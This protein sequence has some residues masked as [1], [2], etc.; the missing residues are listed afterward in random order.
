MVLGNIVEIYLCKERMMV[1]FGKLRE[2]QRKP[3]PI[4]P[5]EIFRRLPKPA[6]MN[7][8]Y[9]SQSDV[10]EKWFNIRNQKDIIFKLHTGGGKTL[11]GLL[12]AQSSLNEKKGPVLYLAPNKNLVS[13]TREKAKDI[14]IQTVSY[15]PG[16]ALHEDF[17]NG[18]AIMV[19]TYSALFNGRSKFGVLGDG[20]ELIETGTIILDDAHSSF[21][22]LRESF[23]FEVSSK[24]DRIIFEE[25]SSLFRSDFVALEKEGTFDSIMSG[26]SNSILE[27]PYWAWNQ[28]KEE[29][30]QILRNL[31][32]NSI[33]WPLI[34][35]YLSYCHAI[36]TKKGFTI[37]PVLPLIHL[38]P[39]FQNAQRR[40]YMS[41][42]IADDSE[43]VR[44]F[45]ISIDSLKNQLKSNSLAGI[46]ERMILI[47]ELMPFQFNIDDTIKKVVNWLS[48][49]KKKVLILTPSTLQSE[50]WRDVSK[51]P[52]NNSEVDTFI[53]ELINGTSDIPLTLINRYDGIDLPGEACRLVVMDEL[54]KGTS[55]Y[56][57]FRAMALAGGAAI[58][59]LLAQRIEQ[60]IG[61]GAR[62]SGDYCI[63]IMAGKSLSSWIARESNFSLLTNATRAQIDMGNT[64]SREISSLK[65]LAETMIK[66]LNRDEDWVEYHAETLAES[67]DE[68]S[69]DNA[70]LE[71]SLTE[72]K[73]IELWLNGHSE[74]AISK[75]REFTTNK[76]VDQKSKGW[77]LQLAAKIAHH[78]GQEELSADLQKEAFAYNIHLQRPQV[79]PPYI[80]MHIPDEQSQSISALFEGY[81]ARLGV[82][83]EFESST[84]FLHENSSSNQFE[85]SLCSLGKYLGF[86]SER[87]D[88]NGDG[89]DVLWITHDKTAYLIEA[90]SGKKEKNPLNKTEHGQLLVA[91]QW[92]IANY[93]KE[94]NILRISVHHDYKATHNAYAEDSFVLT[95]AKIKELK[96]DIAKIIK[97]ISQSQLQKDELPNLASQLLMTSKVHMKVLAQN[98]L[99]NFNKI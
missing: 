17:I 89:P 52:K 27:I 10:L 23:T 39:S 71:H 12:M 68:T 2:N 88:N 8:L 65:E 53:K 5:L 93:G 19:A 60:G 84:S 57:N 97:E 21:S 66:S 28:R 43:L 20:K 45:N 98:Y 56:D 96:T 35:D 30:R 7:D 90:K 13:Q 4:E 69:T 82:Y 54:P 73:S 26:E 32:G 49:N 59:Q 55:D 29:V 41:A 77:L 99:D 15:V 58:N 38:F 25:I 95:M 63:I 94:Y 9:S 24:T 74:K 37:T 62:G 18:K 11:V 72:R 33:S 34:S 50:K 87:F 76:V 3:A 79:K 31:T 91:E 14:G 42:T 81:R 86:S 40:I 64:V 70:N 1:D 51:I 85:E 48:E 44:S 92:F 46:S 80:K 83:R 36:L 78:W 22:V 75:I 16:V 6:G 67:V 61:R 47:P